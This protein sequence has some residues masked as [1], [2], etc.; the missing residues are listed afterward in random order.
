MKVCKIGKIKESINL[1]INKDEKNIVS[2]TPLDLGTQE[3]QISKEKELEVDHLH[4]KYFGLATHY[5]LEMINEFDEKN[6]DY[7]MDLVQTRYSNYLSE[8]D[9]FD[10]KNRLRFLLNDSTFKSLLES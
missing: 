8:D 6:L 2:Y 1:S 7:S 5:C 4:A 9:F 10:I 3:K